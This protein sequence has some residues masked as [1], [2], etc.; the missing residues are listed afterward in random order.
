MSPLFF[1]SVAAVSVR[2]TGGC[3]AGL[4]AGDE[5]SGD[6]VSGAS[7]FCTGIS[8]A[9]VGVGVGVIA[10]VAPSVLSRWFKVLPRALAEP[11]ITVMAIN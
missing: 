5:A 3:G 2:I 4:G 8:R 7:L 11:A 6:E 10:G 1:S 9:A